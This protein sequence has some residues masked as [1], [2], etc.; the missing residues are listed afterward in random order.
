MVKIRS[1]LIAFI[2]SVSA[3]AQTV[4]PPKKAPSSPSQPPGGTPW[5]GGGDAGWFR[6][7]DPIIEEEVEETPLPPPVAAAPPKPE[8][9]QQ[10]A[11]VSPALPSPPPEEV[12][13][14]TEWIRTNL[15]KY[16]DRAMDYPT[17]ENVRAYYALQRVALDKSQTFSDVAQTAFIGNPLIDEVTR[18]PTATYGSSALTIS[19]NIARRELFR[20]LGSRMGVWYFYRADCRFCKKQTPVLQSME[21]EYA[22]SVYAISADGGPVPNGS[23]KNPPRP[24]TGQ[25]EKLGVTATPSL[26]LVRPDTKQILPISQGVLSRDQIIDRI[27]D[28]AHANKWITDKEYDATRPINIV[29]PRPGTPEYDNA[30][31]GL[32]PVIKD[33]EEG[34]YTPIAAPSVSLK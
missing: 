29:G 6:Y 4:E 3:Y 32:I 24:N 22:M 31:R 14:T 9:P 34:G 15:P 10:Q 1:A 33:P 23:F 30:M 8:K 19:A 28:M 21:S 18:R 12:Q 11:V 20:K 25:A 26:F 16:L 13:F 5:L 7:I 27:L 2:L 17:P